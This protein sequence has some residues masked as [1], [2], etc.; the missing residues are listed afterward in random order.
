MGRSTTPKHIAK[1]IYK[2]GSWSIIS[3]KGSTSIKTITKHLT[4]YNESVL[5]PD[6]ANHHIFKELG[7]NAVGIA[8]E[9]RTNT[10]YGGEV[11]NRV[12]VSYEEAIKMVADSFRTATY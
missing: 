5:K 6:G 2:N 3:W 8:I 10:C 9:V 11:V 12:E 7:E 4:K 1:L